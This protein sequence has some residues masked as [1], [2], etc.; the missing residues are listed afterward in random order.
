MGSGIGPRR[1]EKGGRGKEEGGKMAEMGLRSRKVNLPQTGK[2]TFARTVQSA[3]V[4]ENT[5]FSRGVTTR[6]YCFDTVF[7]VSIV[8]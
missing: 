2:V 5:G 4:P 1:E 8:S 3:K 6:R 7:R